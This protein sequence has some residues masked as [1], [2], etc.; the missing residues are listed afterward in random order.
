MTL[1]LWTVYDHPR[2]FPQ[3]FVARRFELD[4][5]T[6]DFIIAPDLQT[7]RDLLMNKGLSCIPRD[8]KDEAHIVETW[9]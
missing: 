7:L 9:L 8:P 2:D 4:Q 6:T 3:S 1:S 5:V